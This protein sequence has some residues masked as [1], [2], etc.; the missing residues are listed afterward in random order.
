MIFLK[1][2]RAEKGEKLLTHV[3]FYS[4]RIFLAK[5]KTLFQ[6]EMSLELFLLSFSSSFQRTSTHLEK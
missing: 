4:Q 3:F 1:K 6:F 5:G 2:R